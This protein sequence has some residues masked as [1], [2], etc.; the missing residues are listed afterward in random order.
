MSCS[1][2]LE[3]GKPLQSLV[4]FVPGGIMPVQLSLTDCP[5]VDGTVTLPFGGVDAPTEPVEIKRVAAARAAASGAAYLS[6]YLPPRVFPQICS[7]KK[8]AD[9]YPP[10]RKMEPSIFCVVYKFLD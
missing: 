6:I 10:A 5:A 7:A 1:S 9:L 8:A 3:D 2:T 4:G